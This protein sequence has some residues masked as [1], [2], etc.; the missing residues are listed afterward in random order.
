MRNQKDSEILYF[1]SKLSE[2][3]YNSN[4]FKV[5]IGEDRFL[6]GVVSANDNEAPFGKLMQY[7]TIYDT[8]KDLDWKIKMSFDEAIKYAYSDSM[9]NDFSLIRTDS[10]EEGLAFYYIENAL[11]RTSSLWDMLAQ[12]YRLFYN[13]DIPKEKV[14]YK[15]IFSP[16]K[17]YGDKFRIKAAEIYEY[18]EQ[19]DNTDCEGEWKGNH[20]FVNDLRNK[21]IHRNS[22]NIA[23][24]SD[25]DMNLKHHPVFQ[26]KRIIEDYVVVSQ[27]IKEILDEIEKEVMSTFDDADC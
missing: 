7:K 13:V 26:L 16:T 3:T 15:Q 20:S 24:M 27:Y 2:V 14:Y 4:R 12:L 17:N 18:I 25:F 1:Q 22:P 10:E 23:V 6:F 5:M 21:M 9:K 11:F 8:L 19:D